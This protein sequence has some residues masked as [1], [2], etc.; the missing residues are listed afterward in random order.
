M[1]WAKCTGIITTSWFLIACGALICRYLGMSDPTGMERLLHHLDQGKVCTRST[2]TTGWCLSQAHT[3]VSTS[4]YTQ[5]HVV[6]Q[7][8]R[9]HEEHCKAHGNH[10][11]SQYFC[12][13]LC[14]SVVAVLHY[15]SSQR[16]HTFA[17]QELWSE[18]PSLM[19]LLGICVTW[20]VHKHGEA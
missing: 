16:H 8:P 11:L 7:S 18:P 9:I 12:L 2:W 20:I 17:L 4:Y 10:M 13:L 1:C 3:T 15:S 6:V 19:T 14:V 5:H